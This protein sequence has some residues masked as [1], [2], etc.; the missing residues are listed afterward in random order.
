MDRCINLSEA[1]QQFNRIAARKSKIAESENNTF[2]RGEAHA[3]SR[4]ASML[5][6]M[7]PVN[8]WISVK[9]R[10]PNEME[11]KSSHSA[12]SA[13][14]R[15]SDDVLICLVN[16]RQTVAWYSYVHNDWTTVEE[17]ISYKEEEVTHWQPLPQSPVK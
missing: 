10:L 4:A 9:D 2:S 6:M 11:D 16:G 14:V 5:G 13:Q 7:Q 17:N 15:P 1:M 8:N 3:W 12:W